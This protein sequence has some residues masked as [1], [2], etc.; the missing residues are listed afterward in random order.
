MD[1][2]VGVV[3]VGTMGSMVMWQLARAG[4]TSVIGFEQFN[5]GHDRSAVGGESRA[6]RTAYLEGSEY[7]PL[8]I[9]SYQQWRELEQDTNV[10]L[11]TL[12]GG[13]TI[14]K[15][16]EITMK[17]MIQCVHDFD[18]DHEIL[19]WKQAKTYY[20]QHMLTSDEII[21]LDRKSG[22]L[23][24][25]LAVLT[26]ARRAEEL[27]AAILRNTPVESIEPHS[28]GVRVHAGERIYE[29][30]KV[31]VTAGPW[32]NRLLPIYND[33]F[34]VNRLLLSW[35]TS[36]NIKSFY[37]DQFPVFVHLTDGIDLF[38]VPTVDGNTVKIAK[39]SSGGEGPVANPDAMNRNVQSE[40]LEQIIQGVK[41]Y[42]PELIPEPIRVTAYM[43]GYTKDHHSLAGYVPKQ[44][45]LLVFGGFSGHGFKLAPVMGKIALELLKTGSSSYAVQHLDP[46]RFLE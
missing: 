5:I 6:F 38:G 20:P 40:D 19:D 43:D 3:G 7:I 9:D 34:E 33:Y 46:N 14:G 37:P 11:L 17:N 22:F 26:A 27:G 15:S 12:T 21:I 16:E 8:L 30:E 28:A 31:V 35:F 13:L 25:E 39:V 2:K 1:A 18:L 42:L 36:K 44:D 10:D 4:I 29:F 23:R 45:N 41:K 24:P 32:L